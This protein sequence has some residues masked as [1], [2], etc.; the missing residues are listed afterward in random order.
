MVVLIYK[1]VKEGMISTLLKDQF[2]MYYKKSKFI[3]GYILDGLY[4]Q[5]R[6]SGDPVSVIQL[7]RSKQIQIH[8]TPFK[9]AC[10]AKPET[11]LHIRCISRSHPTTT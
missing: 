9:R 6:T 3:K 8:G 2:W 5:R 7:Y 1:N 10:F 4:F 11:V